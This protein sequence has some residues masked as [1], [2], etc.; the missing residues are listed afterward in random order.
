MDIAKIFAKWNQTEVFTKRV[1]INN[2][3]HELRVRTKNLDPY[4]SIFVQLKMDENNKILPFFKQEIEQLNKNHDFG[5][6]SVFESDEGT[7]FCLQSAMWIDTQ[8]TNE[9]YEMVLATLE[10]NL[11]LNYCILLERYEQENG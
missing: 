11:N 7:F 10:N 2:I 5:Q 4:F 6:Y 9:N 3:E 8:P 1:M